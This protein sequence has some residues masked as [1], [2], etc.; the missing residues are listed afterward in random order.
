ME[1]RAPTIEDAAAVLGVLEARDIADLG[2][3]DYTLED[4]LD[5]WRAT[6]FDLAADA[7]VAVSDDAGIIGYAAITGPGMTAVV[8]PDHEG[9]G[10]GRR[11]LR[12]AERRERQLG[13]RR[14]RQGVPAGNARGRALLLAA[15]YEP[16]RSY[17]RLTRG[18]DDLPEVDELAAGYRLRPL[19]VDSD[20]KSLHAL[21][22]TVFAANADYREETFDTFCEEHLRVHDLAP[23]L[24]SLAEHDG[25]LVG[26]L[27]ARRWQEEG[28]GFVDLLGVHPDHRGHGLASTMLQTAFARFAAA[29]LREAQLGVASDNPRALTLYERCGMAPRFRI[30]TFERLAAPEA[31]G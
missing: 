22:A 1:F 9:R 23:G 10:V 8:A 25:E 11:L 17:W 7:L 6:E 21:D 18:L 13:R 2:A 31:M 16:G 29:G 27:L 20:A 28:V 19:E 3:P 24:S 14:H 26:F 4:L 15:G 30:D 5:A 12:W